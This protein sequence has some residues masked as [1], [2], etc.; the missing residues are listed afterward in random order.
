MVKIEEVQLWF[1]I[2]TLSGRRAWNIVKG[3]P[4]WNTERVEAAYC[5]QFPERTQIRILT[6]AQA[7]Q[8]LVLHDKCNP[9]EGT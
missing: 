1:V 4:E 7:E 9:P 5:K 2:F 8:D 6:Q 3:G